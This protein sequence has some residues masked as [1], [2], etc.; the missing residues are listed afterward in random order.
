[1]LSTSRGHCGVAS[2]PLK[3]IFIFRLYFIHVSFRG[4]Y[5]CL[6]RTIK[7]GRLLKVRKCNSCLENRAQMVNNDKEIKENVAKK[8]KMKLEDFKDLGKNFVNSMI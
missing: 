6:T 3:L 2:K 4:I 8:V 1:M 5:K 7:N